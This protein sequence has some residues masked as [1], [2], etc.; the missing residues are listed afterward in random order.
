MYRIGILGCE[1]SHATRFVEIFN[2]VKKLAGVD[3]PDMRVVGCYSRYAEVGDKL[4]LLGDLECV[5]EKPEDL[6]GKV[7]AIMVTARDGKYHLPYARPYI[8]AGIPTFIDK[9]FTNS[10]E[11]ALELVRL[12]KAHNVPLTGGSTVKLAYD[13]KMLAYQRANVLQTIQGGTATAPL[14]ISGEYGGFY[15]YSSHLAEMSMTIFGYNPKSV[16][17]FR[18]G[19]NVTAIVHY[20][21]FDVT[22]HFNDGNYTYEATIFSKEKNVSR[23]V[24]GSMNYVN[25]CADFA[26]MLRTGKMEHSFAQLAAPVF[27]I[28][29]ILE[30]YENGGREVE[31]N[32]PNLV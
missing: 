19:R 15:F 17:A 1:N 25:E 21:G 28:N 8:E 29:A 23:V 24:D 7:D 27:Y 22:N 12:A 31:I 32:F 20:D 10:R 9:P 3:Y 4:A 16:N 18:C 6:L 30:S 5:A 13:V 26:S 2:G 14:D 11:D